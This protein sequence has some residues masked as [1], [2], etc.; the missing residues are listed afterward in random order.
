MS[1]DNRCN[2]NWPSG[3]I[4]FELISVS[5]YLGKRVLIDLWK[6]K[7]CSIDCLKY[8]GMSFVPFPKCILSIMRSSVMLYMYKIH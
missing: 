5:L 4:S 8:V 7:G 3:L 6:N 1:S 2:A